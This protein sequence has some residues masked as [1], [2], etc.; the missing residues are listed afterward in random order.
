MPIYQG[1]THERVEKEREE[2]EREKEQSGKQKMVEEDK[3]LHREVEGRG[4]KRIIF[5][6]MSAKRM[7]PVNSDLVS[8][9]HLSK[10]LQLNLNLTQISTLLISRE[11]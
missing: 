9:T 2:K 5:G 8:W 6:P 3:G 10:T 4:G 7:S 1:F 11:F